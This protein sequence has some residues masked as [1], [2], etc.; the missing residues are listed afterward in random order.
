MSPIIVLEEYYAALNAKDFEKALD[1]E[2]LVSN[3]SLS[4]DSL[5][6]L[7]AS[8][9]DLQIL[10]YTLLNYELPK[11]DGGDIPGICERYTVTGQVD[12][13]S[14][15]GA[16]PSGDFGLLYTMVNEEGNWLIFSSGT[17][18]KDS[19]IR[20]KKFLDGRNSE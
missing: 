14:G 5:E 19:C 7:D 12:Y 8:Y 17:F 16:G 18:T 13:P 4:I 15:W 2:M 3:R 1:Y 11:D 6:G 10:P 20:A 9:K